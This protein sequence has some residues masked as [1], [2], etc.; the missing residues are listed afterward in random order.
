MAEYLGFAD[1]DCDVHVRRPTH[2]TLGPM[3]CPCFAPTG[4]SPSTPRRSRRPRLRHVGNCL[5]SKHHIPRSSS[6]Q[7]SV[8][9]IPS[10]LA[11]T[12]GITICFLFVRVIRCFNSAAYPSGHDTG[13]A[14]V[15]G[16]CTDVRLGDL[17]LKGSMRLPAAYR[18]LSR[19]SSASQPSHPPAT[20]SA[21][22]QSY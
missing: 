13:I 17:R 14:Q 9:P 10:S 5:R 19:P 3:T 21:I 7:D 2:A 11:V 22:T 18:S 8:W 20:V 15:I 1:C 12:K 6:L 4:V 16:P